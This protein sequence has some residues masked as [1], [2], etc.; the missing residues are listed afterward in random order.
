MQD[1]LTS[2]INKKENEKE[3]ITIIVSEH[4]EK[5]LPYKMIYHEAKR[6]SN[7]LNSKGIGIGNE[8]LY[9]VEDIEQFI[10]IFWACQLSKVSRNG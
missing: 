3:G 1:L 9:Q 4:V 10:Y 2:F 8:L 5:F 6:Y 7:Y